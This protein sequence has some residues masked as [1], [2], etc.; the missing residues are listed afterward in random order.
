MLAGTI[1][2]AKAQDSLKNNQLTISSYVDAYSATHNTQTPQ[3][4]FQP[5]TAVGARD[6]SLGI[7]IGQIGLNLKMIISVVK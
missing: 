5:Y 6:N 1:S 7:N 4:E 3:D 2:M